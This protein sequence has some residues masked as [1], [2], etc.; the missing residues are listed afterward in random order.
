MRRF[1][2][3]AFRAGRVHFTVAV[4]QR[5]DALS[6]AP[7]TERHLQK[8]MPGGETPGEILPR[9]V[10]VEYELDVLRRNSCCF[11]AL[12]APLRPYARN[13]M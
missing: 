12:L 8:F 7:R 4:E 2:S 1:V 6:V 9:I 13:T 11:P 3:L 5:E 10:I